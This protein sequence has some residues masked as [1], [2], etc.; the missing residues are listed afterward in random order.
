MAELASRYDHHAVEDRWYRFWMERGYFRPRGS[1]PVFS[2]VLPPPNVTGVLHLGH[3][4]NS[5]WQDILVR[6][7]RMKGDDTLWVPGTDHAGI[8]TQM[9]VEELLRSQGRDRRE[10]GREAF[11]EEAWAW[12]ER[13]GGIILEQ[14]KK[15]GVSVD[16]DRLRFTLDEGLSKAVVEVFVRLWEEGLIYRGD[17]IT[18][19]CVSC[20]TALSDIEVEHIEEPGSLTTIRYPLA[21]GSGRFIAVATTRPETLL[22]DTAVAVHP[23]DPRWRDFI[24]RT[25]VVPLVERP[26]P[27]VADRAVDPEYGTGAVKVT[28]AHDPN[29]FAIGQ[30]H[31]L[32]AVKVIGEDGR[33]TAEAGA[34]YQGLTREEAR[35]LVL[36]DLRHQGLVVAE[37][38]ITHAVGH[39][40]K[41]GTIIEPLLSRQW[42]VRIAPLAGPAL[43]AV[44]TGAVR[45][46]PERFAKVYLNW[47]TN[48]HD[49]CISRQLWWGHRIPAYYCDACGE[50]T[51]ART[52]P[53]ACPRCGGPV[54][55]DEDVLD[56]WFSSALWPFSTLG[57]PDITPDFSRYYP[58]SVLSTG[59]D[60]I[61]FWVARMIMQGIH[62]TGQRPFSV[63]LLHGLIR[64]REGRKMSKSLGNGVDPLQVVEAYG[65]DAL[66]MG[67]VMG[68]TPGNDLRYSEERIEAAARFANKVYNAVRF[69]RLNLEEEDRRRLEEDLPVV[70]SPADRWIR[71]RLARTVAAVGDYLDRFEFGEAARAIYDFLW[72]E[73]CDWYIELAKRRLKTSGPDRD[74]ALATLVGVARE[75]LALLHPFMPF[76]TEELWQAL[77]HA[78]ESLMVAPWPQAAGEDEAA[79][80]EMRLVQDLIRTLRNLRAELKLPPS[81]AVDAVAV[82]EDGEAARVWRREAES[83]RLL[84]RVEHLEVVE[85][86]QT[87]RRPEPAISGVTLG[88]PV[89]V[90][91]LGVVDI[92]QERR[93]LGKLLAEAR[94][95]QERVQR[96]LAD[97]GFLD[98]A[99][100]DV[101]E[102]TARQ[103]EEVAARLA[104][105]AA[106]LEELG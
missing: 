96:R 62:F 3:A 20:G 48:I 89:Y 31:S 25:A 60:I 95:E 53:E 22:G 15:L 38:P 63:V 10:M 91:L 90:P 86:G 4:L 12:R 36:E 93:R 57:W 42:F 7:H 21:D 6:Y 66:R 23:D 11:L 24:G 28:P 102:A 98:R 104:R 58:T 54:H 33:M 81:Q 65:A 16:W 80:A 74:A 61:F 34:R 50:V 88:G 13:Y 73:Y 14:L 51:V 64:D 26:V 76:L 56:T 8:H 45:F 75:A 106:R 99:P 44:R 67:L 1:G 97:R 39:C 32:P 72:D 79:E 94:A 69:V 18:N 55:Q 41:C 40:E 71:S 30:R 29:D 70:L 17:Y 47:M 82:A 5:T 87:W 105:L 84:A 101:V 92:E 35:E 9:K 78:G 100:A 37:E 77:P 43:E 103:A 59:Y 68:T 46:V 2:V 49:W 83:V 19:W 85:P 27:I 52:A